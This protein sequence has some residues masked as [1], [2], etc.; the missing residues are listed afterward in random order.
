MYNLNTSLLM[1]MFPC[2]IISNEKE[3]VAILKKYIGKT[4]ELR[5]SA[6]STDPVTARQEMRDGTAE[7]I[8][9]DT[10]MPQL[11]SL[12]VPDLIETRS[13]VCIY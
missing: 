8:F 11:A 2:H 6:I 12:L 3:V 1:P 10:D 5:L 7:I 9:I 4:K 13:K